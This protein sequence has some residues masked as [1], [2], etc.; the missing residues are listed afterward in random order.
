LFFVCSPGKKS[1]NTSKEE[2]NTQQVTDFAVDGAAKSGTRAL[3][4]SVVAF[5]LAMVAGQ[6]GYL[7]MA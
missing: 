5:V 6:V 3:H 1:F 7:L 2:E 4:Q